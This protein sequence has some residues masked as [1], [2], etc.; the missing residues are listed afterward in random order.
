MRLTTLV[1]DHDHADRFGRW[2][3]DGTGQKHVCTFAGCTEEG[4]REASFAIAGASVRYDDPAGIRF[5]TR[6]NKN[7][8]FKDIY[9]GDDNNY[10]YSGAN[11]TFGTLIVPKDMLDGELTASTPGVVNVVAKKVYN[12]GAYSQTSDYFY[13]TAV[14]VNFP[15]SISTY[16]RDLAVRSYAMYEENEET[17]YIYTDTAVTSFYKVAE[18]VYP[19]QSQAVK[20]GLNMLLALGSV[21]DDFYSKIADRV[22]IL[23]YA[24]PELFNAFAASL[25]SQGFTRHTNYEYS[26]N[27]FGLYYNSDFVVTFYYTPS[28]I[29]NY[30]EPNEEWYAYGS[31]PTENMDRIINEFGVTV[32]D[33]TNIMRVIVEK[34]SSVDLPGTE[35]ENVY[36][37]DETVRNSVGF[38]FPNDNYNHYG[39]GYIIQLADGS[40]IIVDGG[41]SV[42]DPRVASDKT[43]ADLLYDYLMSKKPAAHE[44][45]VIAAWFL[46]HRHNDHVDVLKAFAPKYKDNVVL[47]QIVYNFA[48]GVKSAPLAERDAMRWADEYAGQ[49]FTDAKIVTA[50]TGYKFYIRNAEVTILYSIDDLYPF[51]ITQVFTNNESIVF[52]VVIDD[53]QRLMFCNEVFVPGS[54]AL[55]NMFGD[56]LASDVIQLSHH[57]HYGATEELYQ[58]IWPASQ[59]YSSSK[60]FVLW[61][62]G[63]EEQMRVR[64]GLAENRWI[65]KQIG[66]DVGIPWQSEWDSQINY[67]MSAFYSTENARFR[68]I[69]NYLVNDSRFGFMRGNTIWDSKIYSMAQMIF[70][71]GTVTDRYNQT[72][73][74]YV[75]G[76]GAIGAWKTIPLY[77]ES[78]DYDTT[79]PWPWG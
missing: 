78:P 37:R 24:S 39:E 45:P 77:T 2:I 10:T 68:T 66:N 52:D 56:D 47:E 12:T 46:S 60:R 44:K 75:A 1:P 74:T 32:D 33:A 58:K 19:S 70:E 71:S 62:C 23:E 72:E 69:G 42:T 14:L 8:F 50:H 48:A 11:I 53:V 22:E 43:D 54:R 27:L 31:S 30:V 25:E 16:N 26:D 79:A 35:A 20:E 59:D 17:V 51:D 13:Y 5:L 34:R 73:N 3:A 38:I 28:T 7:Q 41:E 15:E 9:T 76:S 18:Q 61:P 49:Y 55:V 57:G 63:N 65:L 4:A 29:A 36:E 64:C 40:F 67:Y 6:V 21:S